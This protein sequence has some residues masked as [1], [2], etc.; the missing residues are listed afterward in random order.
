[1]LRG[2]RYGVAITERDLISVD[3]RRSAVQSAGVVLVAVNLNQ[4]NNRAHTQ[5]GKNTDLAGPE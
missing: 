2:L 3:H 4:N 1:M 5:K